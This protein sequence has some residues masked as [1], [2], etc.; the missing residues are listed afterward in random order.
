MPRKVF[1][2]LSRTLGVLSRH[3]VL[4]EIPQS[5]MFLSQRPLLFPAVKTIIFYF[6]TVNLV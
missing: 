6:L 4:G 3:L 1:K 5:V 2:A